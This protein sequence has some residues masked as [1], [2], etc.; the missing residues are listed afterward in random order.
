MREEI[1]H[2][3]SLISRA[4]CG[5]ASLLFGYRTPSPLFLYPAPCLY[6][7]LSHHGWA[8]RVMHM[9]NDVLCTH[10]RPRRRTSVIMAPR[11]PAASSGDPSIANGGGLAR[12]MAKVL[13]SSPQDS[14]LVHPGS[15][16]FKIPGGAR[17]SFLLRPRANAQ[18]AQ[19]VRMLDLPAAAQEMPRGWAP[20]LQLR[21]KRSRLSWVWSEASLERPWRQGERG[22]GAPSAPAAQPDAPEVFVERDRHDVRQ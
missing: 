18:P 12:S 17:P 8:L 2:R 11:K 7:S 4:A 22:G 16:Y 13:R 9:Y 3:S 10:E 6:P 14:D 15:D 1:D 21:V 19:Q 20:M 5:Y